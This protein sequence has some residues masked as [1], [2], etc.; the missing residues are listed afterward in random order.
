MIFSSKFNLVFIL[1]TTLLVSTGCLKTRSEVRAM[2]A[3]HEQKEKV[4]AQQKA[5]ALSKVDDLSEQ[6]RSLMGRVESLET[7]LSE[8]ERA[9][10]EQKIKVENA[11]L[12]MK[13]KLSVYEETINKLEA[14]LK[15]A[16]NKP[17][18][19]GKP[20]KIMNSF[21]KGDSA[22]DAKDWKEA[23]LNYQKYRDQNPTGK[24]YSE[25]TYKI[26]VSFQ[27]LGM[28]SEA[29]AFFDE[30]VEKYPKSQSATRAK[31]RL[32]NLK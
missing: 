24:R 32:K 27:E 28:K 23:I 11:E 8:S 4:A 2:E 14:Q 21:D 25:A 16:G 17:V 31:T 30:V 15:E 19:K 22:F 10:E 20:G 7:R 18:A 13:E 5:E 6:N 3:Q 1:A 9:R 12:A 26:G 29:K